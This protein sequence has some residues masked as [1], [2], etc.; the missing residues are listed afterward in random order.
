MK[1]PPTSSA[2]AGVRSWGL[3]RNQILEDVYCDSD[4]K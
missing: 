1:E 2:E 3:L 4:D